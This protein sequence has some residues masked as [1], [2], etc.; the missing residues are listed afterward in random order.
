[1]SEEK[2]KRNKL[3]GEISK[4]MWKIS[5]EKGIDKKAAYREAYKEITGKE[6][7]P[8]PKREVQKD[9][10]GKTIRKPRPKLSEE[11]RS[12]KRKSKDESLR[13]MTPEEY[14][15]YTKKRD[16]RISKR[17]SKKKGDV[18]KALEEIKPEAAKNE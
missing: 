4:L 6:F 12:V 7:V 10:D 17:K 8:K 18:E 1:M 15:A 13:K 9:A 3:F 5:K 16:D 14:E 11:E 2:A